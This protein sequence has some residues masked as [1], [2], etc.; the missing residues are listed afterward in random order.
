MIYLYT[1]TEHYKKFVEDNKSNRL[2]KFIKVLPESD[3]MNLFKLSLNSA[4]N[5]EIY[6]SPIET[7]Y[8]LVKV[9]NNFLKVL[10]T[11]K[12]NTNYRLDIHI[13]NEEN[14]IVNHISFTENDSKY[15]TIPD[16]QYGFDQY[17][18]DYNRLTGKNEMIEFMDRIHFILSDLLNKGNL[19]NNLFCIG[20]TELEKNN[21]YEYL[22]KVVVGDN[23]FK[24]IETNIYPKVGWGLYFSIN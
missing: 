14:G 22:L 23:G 10:F 7:K 3:K 19:S 17:E 13:I 16:N 20:G 15:D 18:S 24:K 8:N 21:I 2:S 11:S 5:E 9:N 12:S 1:K 6:G 4:F